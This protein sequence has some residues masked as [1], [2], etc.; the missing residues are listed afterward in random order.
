MTLKL[1]ESQTQTIFIAL[2]GSFILLFVLMAWLLFPTRSTKDSLVTSLITPTSISSP[3]PTPTPFPSPIDNGSGGKT[4]TGE[5]FTID[6]PN[7]WDFYRQVILNYDTSK[8][9]PKQGFPKGSVKCDFTSYDSED[10]IEITSNFISGETQVKK[11]KIY[12]SPEAMPGSPEYWTYFLI[13]KG[14]L[15]KGVICYA[16]DI[17]QEPV[18]K[19]ILSTFKFNP[20]E[21]N[22][23]GGFFGILCPEGYECKLDGSY[24]DAGGKC[25]KN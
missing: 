6:V 22:F 11:G 9:L 7:G 15:S 23:C 21:E 8:V 2:L 16:Y 3:F 4:Y 13:Q 5:G 14:N 25:L 12:S 24:P 20:I 19:Q 17:N 18:F 1:Q 10:K